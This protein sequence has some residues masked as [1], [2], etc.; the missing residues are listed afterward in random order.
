MC[1]LTTEK[2]NSLRAVLI[3]ASAALISARNS[4]SDV[5]SCIDDPMDERFVDMQTFH[6]LDGAHTTAEK[7]VIEIREFL[8]SN[9]RL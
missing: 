4:L 3:E 5:L 8:K 6:E 2:Y 1:G 9:P 7:K